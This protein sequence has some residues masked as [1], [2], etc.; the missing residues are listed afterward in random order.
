M[1]FISLVPTAGVAAVY[2]IE[3]VI[4][5]E[6]LWLIIFALRFPNDAATGWRRFAER[7]ILLALPVLIAV[8]F[9]N[10]EGYLLGVPPH[11]A[12]IAFTNVISIAGLI[13]A[14]LTFI[15]TYVAAKD[16]DR[17]RIR[18]VML[19]IVVRYGGQSMTSIVGA[20]PGVSVVW[21]LWLANLAP[22]LQVV[23][24]IAVAYAVIR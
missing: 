24:A 3:S 8:D 7:A 6:S 14:A 4:S 16:A 18:W 23:V 13:G 21:P 17:A 20:L 1:T 10:T 15:A 2:A 22:S 5:Y 9:W 12:M 19:G 11:S